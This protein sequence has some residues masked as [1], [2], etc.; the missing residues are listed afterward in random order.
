MP[1]RVL[2]RG[3]HIVHR[4]EKHCSQTTGAGTRIR[5]ALLKSRNLAIKICGKDDLCPGDQPEETFQ[6]CQ[7]LTPLVLNE[8]GSERQ[9]PHAVVLV[10]VVCYHLNSFLRVSSQDRR[11]RNL[12]SSLVSLM[13]GKCGRNHCSLTS[14]PFGCRLFSHGHRILYCKPP[15]CQGFS[16]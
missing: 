9:R 16:F 1:S 12:L 11:Q 14:A 4:M 2:G 5:Q 6:K 10:L 7:R 8:N 3:S 13:T 15:L